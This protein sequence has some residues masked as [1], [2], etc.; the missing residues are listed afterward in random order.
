MRRAP[1][2]SAA[3]A[4]TAAALPRII[5][6]P[7]SQVPASLLP[8]PLE[9]FGSAP[10]AP[11]FELANTLD[12][13]SNSGSA[14]SKGATIAATASAVVVAPQ[15][16]TGLRCV[17]WNIANLGGKYGYKYP[18]D[19]EVIAAIARMLERS[20]ADVIVILEVLQRTNPPREPKGLSPLGTASRLFTDDPNAPKRPTGDPKLDGVG[21]RKRK[22]EA[23]PAESAPPR[24]KFDKAIG[25]DIERAIATAFHR[26]FQALVWEGRP[27][28]DLDK[29][30]DVAEFGEAL[31]PAARKA[32]YDLGPDMEMAGRNLRKRINQLIDEDY[33]HWSQ[34]YQA[35][36]PPSVAATLD[37]EELARVKVADATSKLNIAE[38]F[39]RGVSFY[40]FVL[41]RHFGCPIPGCRRCTNNALCERHKNELRTASRRIGAIGNEYLARILVAQTAAHAKAVAAYEK[42][43]LKKDP[44]VLDLLRI[45]EAL[46]G[47][48]SI[49]YE[50]WHKKDGKHQ[51]SH[52]E[53][54]GLFWNK[55]RI[56]E[57]SIGFAAGFDMR[58]PLCAT[59]KVD[60]KVDVRLLGWHAPSTGAK[61]VGH[62]NRDFGR[63][64]A[65]CDAYRVEAQPTLTLLL[66]DLNIDTLSEETIGAQQVAPIQ[67]C[68]PARYVGDF[69]THLTGNPQFLEQDRFARRP[70][71]LRASALDEELRPTL[72]QLFFKH[73]M[74]LAGGSKMAIAPTPSDKVP[75]R[76]DALREML[77][78]LERNMRDTRHD[79]TLSAFD[80]ICTMVNATKTHRFVL[81]QQT[82]VDLVR[83]VAGKEH[84]GRFIPRTDARSDGALAKV[85][86]HCFQEHDK[87]EFD[88]LHAKAPAADTVLARMAVL[89]EATRKLSDH[90]LLVADF[91]IEPHKGPSQAP[92]KTLSAEELKKEEE[93]LRKRLDEL[94][95]ARAA[96]KDTRSLVEALEADWFRAGSALLGAEMRAEQESPDKPQ[97]VRR[98]LLDAIASEVTPHLLLHDSAIADP[99]TAQKVA[100]LRAWAAAQFARL[101]AQAQGSRPIDLIA[102]F[103]GSYVEGQAFE[104]LGD[105]GSNSSRDARV[106]ELQNND[107]AGF[108]ASAAALSANPAVALSNAQPGGIEQATNSCY[109][110]SICQALGALAPFLQA[111]GGAVGVAHPSV[112]RIRL[113]LRMVLRAVNA[114]QVTPRNAVRFLRAALEELGLPL[115]LRQQDADEVFT[116]LVERM[117]L[118]GPFNMSVVLTP[119]GLDPRPE[120]LSKIDMPLPESEAG[121]RMDG[122]VDA[123]F[124]PAD[125]AQLRSILVSPGVLLVVAKRY[126][127]NRAD[128]TVTK[129]RT[130]I[131]HAVEFRTR[132]T[133][134]RAEQTY[135]LVA[136]IEHIG[137]SPRG[138]HYVCR[139]LRGNQWYL[140]NDS[141]VTAIAAGNGQVVAGTCTAFQDSYM[142]F[143]RL[144][145]AAAH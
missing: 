103:W 95:A 53:T 10:P 93:L 76:V 27:R 144:R 132:R 71:T 86:D 63:L 89:L 119:R 43:D 28:A 1:S 116:F 46:N 88:A 25:A 40:G 38:V 44:G 136:A 58:A 48:S 98:R 20:R 14:G 7:L 80:K 22:A 66:S 72:A 145:P 90:T 77:N 79:T 123:F 33:V 3:A 118:T 85:F 81:G 92:F 102:D 73:S 143:Y 78:L 18:R 115:G 139:T 59:L 9:R 56:T 50:S 82:V 97:S 131:T 121:L 17:L 117:L 42:A 83:A 26:A 15:S 126:A 125:G 62:R 29:V 107:I 11:P 91:T 137:A 70:T 111:L 140:A 114:S 120:D 84:E 65:L 101:G 129:V 45:Q 49:K 5:S 47:I 106:T 133:A 32:L 4:A 52:A 130:P 138:G 39:Q 127:F 94:H 108:L 141:T 113:A 134:D 37:E 55:T 30:L 122:L 21:S 61:H 112:L 12:V 57:G 100:E 105:L 51:Y 67:Q 34:Q 124:H 41:G 36:Y 64:L 19:P 8:V 128:L 2:Q 110:A 54:V 35:T 60:G 142:F 109:L 74:Q 16:R 31:S 24:P 87:A 69:F 104:D 99:H 13:D 23:T 68:N 75:V 135:D 6:V 96:K